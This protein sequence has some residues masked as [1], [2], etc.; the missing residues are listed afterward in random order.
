LEFSAPSVASGVCANGG[1]NLPD[2]LS[3]SISALVDFITNKILALIPLNKR[4]TK[5]KKSSFRHILL[6]QYLARF[7]TLWGQ[8]IGSYHS[9][10]Y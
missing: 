9:Q 2:A 3:L 6:N 8:N 1:T 7:L 4:P 5:A 10:D